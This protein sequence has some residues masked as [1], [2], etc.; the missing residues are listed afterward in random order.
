[1]RSETPEL[2]DDDKKRFV[3]SGSISLASAGL[4]FASQRHTLS[5]RAGIRPVLRVPGDRS[6]ERRAEGTMR[7]T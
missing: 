4:S 2:G 5:F 7:G 6:T 3:Q 1:M